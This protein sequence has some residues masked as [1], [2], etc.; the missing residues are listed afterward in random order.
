MSSS[1]NPRWLCLKCS[2]TAGFFGLGRLFGE[3]FGR[4]I[5]MF[6]SLRLTGS[7]SMATSGI[8]PSSSLF[9]RITGLLGRSGI[10]FPQV[11]GLRSFPSWEESESLSADLLFEKSLLV[12]GNLDELKFGSRSNRLA[13]DRAGYLGRIGLWDQTR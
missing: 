7:V 4:A 13:S 2:S 8:L 5:R 12:Q 11:P 9:T 6:A 10:P 3:C 1:R